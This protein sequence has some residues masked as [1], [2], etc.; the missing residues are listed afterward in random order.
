MAVYY[1]TNPTEFRLTDSVIIAEQEQPP[2]GNLAGGQT[3]V[4]IVGE[5]P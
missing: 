5:F 4:G 3:F 2:S 1:T